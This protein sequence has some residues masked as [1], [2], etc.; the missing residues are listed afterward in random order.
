MHWD[1]A[2]HDLT[3]DGIRIIDYSTNAGDYACVRGV[4]VLVDWCDVMSCSVVPTVDRC[5]PTPSTA[6]KTVLGLLARGVP[7]D[8]HQGNRPNVLLNTY[9]TNGTSR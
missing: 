7:L 6:A 8:F 9:P 5:V 1:D 3:A 4:D 2:P